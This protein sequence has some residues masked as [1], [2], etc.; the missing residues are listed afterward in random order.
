MAIS[1]CKKTS[2]FIPGPTTNDSTVLTSMFYLDTTQAPV[3]DTLGKFLFSYDA[4]KRL[5]NFKEHINRAHTNALSFTTEFKFLYSGTDT[6]PEKVY[7]TTSNYINYPTISSSYDTVF[8]F[9]QNGKVI[10]DSAFYTGITNVVNINIID[11]KK[12]N[13]TSWYYTYRRGGDPVTTLN[14]FHS[15]ANWQNDNLMESIDSVYDGVGSWGKTK[16][17]QFSYDNHPN[18]LRKAFYLFPLHI[19][20]AGYF[21]PNFGPFVMTYLGNSSSNNVTFQ[22]YTNSSGTEIALWEYSY[23]SNGLPTSGIWNNGGIRRKLV[24]KYTKL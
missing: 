18:P 22:N 4:T 14:T 19:N 2:T 23:A 17:F 8:L 15:Y 9:Y 3:G 20:I 7:I 16:S 11:L 13:N 10:K 1:S 5:I 21:S 6:L 24:Y 12:V